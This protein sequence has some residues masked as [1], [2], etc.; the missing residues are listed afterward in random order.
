MPSKEVMNL[1]NTYMELMVNAI[2][3]EGGT[4]TGFWGDEL[5]AIFNA[6]LT[7]EDH[8]LRAVRAAWKMRLAVLDIIALVNCPG[9]TC[10][11]LSQEPS[12]WPTVTSD[13][14]QPRR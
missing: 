13:E 3:D 10:A 9:W 1:L 12:A 5:M 8:A 4:V 11:V 6:P 2:W 14:S 7:Q